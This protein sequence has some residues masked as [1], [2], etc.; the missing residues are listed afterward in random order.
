MKDKR[1][2][3]SV[4]YSR[5]K[6]GLGY[7]DQFSVACESPDTAVQPKKAEYHYAKHE[8][9]RQEPYISVKVLLRNRRVL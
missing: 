1:Y 3:N 5:D 8:V 6:T 9:Y 4:E 2:A 7:I